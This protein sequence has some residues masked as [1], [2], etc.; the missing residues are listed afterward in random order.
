MKVVSC[1]LL[2]LL[3]M[4]AFGAMELK[5]RQTVD[6]YGSSALQPNLADVDYRMSW[7]LSGELVED[8]CVP[9]QVLV[10]LTATVTEP[11]EWPQTPEWQNYRLALTAYERLV[12]ER[13]LLAADWLER[14][15]FDIAPQ[16]DC[17]Q[18]HRV[19]DNV[20]YHQ[21]GIAQT[22]LKDF[23][24]EQDFGRQLGLIRPAQ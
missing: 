4:P 23:Q 17:L 12:R 21:L 10:S 11:L 14:S 20:G 7:Q 24:R 15:L 13:A 3:A 9:S 6:V 2:T 5:A 8:G 16:A 1:A 19:A 18:L 22:L